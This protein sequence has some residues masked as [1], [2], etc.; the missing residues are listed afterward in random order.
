VSSELKGVSVHRGVPY[1][2]ALFRFA[3]DFFIRSE[4]AFLAAA[5][6]F[7]RFRFA[8]GGPAALPGVLFLPRALA[9]C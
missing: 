6:I 5:L 4:I 7:R 3:Q 9:A 8:L 1:R 2:L